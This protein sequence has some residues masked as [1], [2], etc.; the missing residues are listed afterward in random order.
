MNK[1]Q[2]AEKYVPINDK[3]KICLLAPTGF[4]KTSFLNKIIGFENTTSPFSTSNA[5][6]TV[7]TQQLIISST[8]KY[9]EAFIKFKSSKDLKQLIENNLFN[10]IMEAQK[11]K[12][13]N[14]IY[15][16]LCH[17][18]NTEFPL[19]YSLRF[20]NELTQEL[21]KK[22]IYLGEILVDKNEDKCEEELL[23]MD[24]YKWCCDKILDHLLGLIKKNI[25]IGKKNSSLIFE[26]DSIFLDT[27]GLW[28]KSK[29]T[30]SLIEFVKL[31]TKVIT[32]G[33][34]EFLTPIVDII[35]LKIHPSEIRTELFLEKENIE[36]CITDT[37]GIG[38]K[39]SEISSE[40]LGHITSSDYFFV[41]QLAG[42]G[43]F[44]ETL[45]KFIATIANA[46]F[47]SKLRMILT[48]F[49]MQYND[50]KFSGENVSL[51]WDLAVKYAS[52]PIESSLEKIINETTE[53]DQNEKNFNGTFITRK[54]FKRIIQHLNDETYFSG[55][56]YFETKNYDSK[57]E[58]ENLKYKESL[59]KLF[60]SLE[61]TSK[62][63]ITPLDLSNKDNYFSV[64]DKNKNKNKNFQFDQSNDSS[65][66][67]EEFK[68]D[69]IIEKFVN[70]EMLKYKSVS[71][72]TVKALNRRYAEKTST[73]WNGLD[74][75]S[76]FVQK[77]QEIFRGY[78]EKKLNINEDKIDILC[79]SFYS[80]L[81]DYTLT[82][83]FHE[84]NPSWV[85]SF[86]LFGTGS[87]A[88]R[89]EKIKQ[90]LET[91]LSRNQNQIFD[92]TAIQTSNFLLV[93]SDSVIPE[94]TQNHPPI[95]ILDLN[96][97]F[98]SL[99]LK[100][101][102][103]IKERLN[104][105]LDSQDKL[106]CQLIASYLA[107]NPPQDY[108]EEEGLLSIIITDFMNGLKSW[109]HDS[110]GNEILYDEEKKIENYLKNELTL[111]LQKDDLKNKFGSISNEAMFRIKHK[112]EDI[113]SE[114][115]DVFKLRVKAIQ[116]YEYSKKAS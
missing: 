99:I 6:T 26:L 78:I 57:K 55:N 81:Y 39:G 48:K 85:E 46:G 7:F 77:T 67:L 2:V 58:F 34:D 105:Y 101:T 108:D 51:A 83:L 10:S 65:K 33:K 87:T 30:T 23:T 91:H 29:D 31:F 25:E 111:L 96:S 68:M 49:D 43:G 3:V 93:R 95:N 8:S 56:Y 114:V 54:T 41:L 38:Q 11:S 116:F 47:L 32:N 66:L 27:E 22:I 103:E 79:Q 40:V 15:I 16:K 84:A 42:T 98:D 106:G 107:H 71:W 86:N 13:P 74:P 17:D 44:N 73:F 97:N 69:E 76:S 63:K 104:Y 113:F 70:D 52:G 12:D 60:I 35:R 18:R 90:L 72:Q 80:I 92:S 5:T 75:V 115:L 102:K 88:A 14:K 110:F 20:D 62:N 100:V 50:P 19:Y 9:T 59:M 28:I 94:S 21:I 61:L 112:L 82:F 1:Y 53:V 4:G 37:V 24:D 64:I 89:R 45:L 36:V 109:H